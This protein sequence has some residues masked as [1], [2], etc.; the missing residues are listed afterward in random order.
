MTST[1]AARPDLPSQYVPAD[2]EGLL[3]ERWVERG[4]FTA[5]P[6][7]DKPPYSMV[8]P[9]PNVTSRLH[10]G[11][12]LEQ[13]M[14]DALTRRARMQGHDVLWLPGMDHASIA[15][16]NLVERY[17]A[18]TEGKGRFD[19]SRAD[20]IAK[21]WDWK[22]RFGGEITG[23]MRRLGDGMDWTRERFT[24]DEGLSRAVQTI[25]KRL[26]DDDLIYRAVRIIN[27]CPRD[28]TA[29]SDIVVDLFEVGG[30]LLS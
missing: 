29:L 27:W 5:D 16:Q 24:M 4:Y 23:Q 26:Y 28:L 3:Y 15:V 17:L 22:E 25:F 1:P 18:E 20:F 2:V 12:A 6:S 30:E 21:A 8:I 11:H 14:M 13:S 10:I 19:Y 9:P 7:S